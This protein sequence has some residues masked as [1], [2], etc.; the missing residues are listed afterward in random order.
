MYKSR[1]GRS[2]EQGYGYGVSQI[3][4][5]PAPGAA[6]RTL[7]PLAVACLG[8][9]LAACG[10]DRSRAPAAPLGPEHYVIDAEDVPAPGQHIRYA[11]PAVGKAGGLDIAIT[12]YRPADGGPSVAL[13][14]VV[15]VADAYYF[16]ALQQELDRF[17]TVLYEGVKPE[18]FTKEDWQRSFREGG[19]E[20]ARLQRDLAGWFGFEYQLEAL[21][22]SRKNF[23]HAD[24]SME[25]FLAEGGGSLLPGIAGA[26]ADAKRSDGTTASED[27]VTTRADAQPGDAGREAVEPVGAIGTDIR[28]T[29]NAVK[30]FGDVALG[31]PGP[32][33]SL[34]R[35]MFAETMGTTD[36]GRVLE[37]RP[38]FSELILIRR[39]E[40]VMKRLMEVLPTTEGPIA[41]F[42]GAAHMRDLEERLA[43]LGY[44]RGKARWLRAWAIRPPLR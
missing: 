12:E 29:W 41:I 34:A 35:K 26:A 30:Q 22:Y 7:R 17:P 40:V 21:D 16:D 44:E 31:T 9:L 13:V 24:M 32:L 18:D 25:D 27:A 42:Y 8:L 23:V 3:S 14:G 6:R 11:P 38:G 36:I 4:P 5:H 2:H 43:K 39:N 19:G 37:M 28:A 10:P 15:H 1:N 20:A 33:R